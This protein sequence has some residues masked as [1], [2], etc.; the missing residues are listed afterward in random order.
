M[1]PCD[2]RIGGGTNNAHLNPTRNN[3]REI[4]PLNESYA[5]IEEGGHA[6]IKEDSRSP[7]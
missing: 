5:T 7:R 6:G 3:S 2:L 1:K 4:A